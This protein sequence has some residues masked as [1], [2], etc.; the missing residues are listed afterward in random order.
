MQ[1]LLNT[2]EAAEICCLSIRT[3]ERLR[4][5]GGGPRFVRLRGSVR[6][7]EQSLM[8]WIAS[9]EVGSTSEPIKEHSNA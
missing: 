4:C 1:R 8:E 2:A 9:R 5:V 7:W 3:L 6:Y